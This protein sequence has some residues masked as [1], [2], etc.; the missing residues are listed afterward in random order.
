M[1][2]KHV[3]PER[4]MQLVTGHWSLK[5]LAVAVDLSVR[6]PLKVA[7]IPTFRGIVVQVR[8]FGL[9]RAKKAFS[10]EVYSWKGHFCHFQPFREVSREPSTLYAGKVRIET[11]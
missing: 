2:T 9:K 8:I 11:R 1:N 6:N 5:A 7:I 4:I 3:S 10:A